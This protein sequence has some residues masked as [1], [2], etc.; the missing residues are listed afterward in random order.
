MFHTNIK[1]N[2]VFISSLRIGA[3]Q[4]MFPTSKSQR[5]RMKYRINYLLETN[6]LN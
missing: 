5:K 6:M 1:M 3:Q 2:F 4:P